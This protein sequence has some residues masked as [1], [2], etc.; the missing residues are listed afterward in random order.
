MSRDRTIY[1]PE[2]IAKQLQLNGMTK[3]SV[4]KLLTQASD[5]SEWQH[6]LDALSLMP[7]EQ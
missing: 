1:R 3:D 2:D 6:V 7:Q 5:L 4:M